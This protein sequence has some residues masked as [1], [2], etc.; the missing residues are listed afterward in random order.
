MN[1]SSRRHRRL[2]T[3][4]QAVAEFALVRTTVPVAYANRLGWGGSG[5]NL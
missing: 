4:G 5:N 3:S 2:G 1:R